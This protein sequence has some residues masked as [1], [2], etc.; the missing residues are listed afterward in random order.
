[1]RIGYVVLHYTF[2]EITDE[3][4]ESISLF[5]PGAPLM[6]VDNGSIIPYQSAYSVLHL[7]ENIS[8]AA[9]MNAGTRTLLEQSDVDIVFQLNNDIRITGSIAEEVRWVFGAFPQVGI[10]SPLMDQK[11]ADF[12]YFPCPYEPGEEAEKYLAET[13]PKHKKLTVPFVDNAAFAIRRAAW[14]QVGILEERFTGASWGANYDYC[15]RARKLNWEVALVKS[16]FV[17]HKH[18]ATWNQLD[19][20]YFENSVNSMMKQT[21]EIWGDLACKVL[22]RD[23]K[24]RQK[25]LGEPIDEGTYGDP[26][27]AQ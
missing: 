21:Q 7:P 16:A 24:W 18:R 5:D 17:F 11:D 15:W 27:C 25:Y 20:N 12:A 19:Q 22:W 9:A 26:P 13:L 3:C 10:A 8:L 6:V 4:L 1:M 2:F 14:E 23:K